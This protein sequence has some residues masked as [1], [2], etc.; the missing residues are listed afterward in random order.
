MSGAKKT[1]PK[2]LTPS[3]INDAFA[4]AVKT[5]F[6]QG[7][8]TKPT[9][10]SISVSAFVTGTAKDTVQAVIV[11]SAKNI[12]CRSGFEF[13][14][15]QASSAPGK[16]EFLFHY[17]TEKGKERVAVGVT[18]DTDRAFFYVKKMASTINKRSNPWG[19]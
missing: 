9:E 2:V 17:G 1:S 4:E 13:S 11:D 7:I 14:C 10:N 5:K 12:L 18:M 8:V 16:A 3:I 15:Q 6:N 19:K